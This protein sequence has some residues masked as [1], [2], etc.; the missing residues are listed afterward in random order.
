VSFV[1][2]R[3]CLLEALDRDGCPLRPQDIEL[4]EREICRAHQYMDQAQTLRT[5]SQRRGQ[6]LPDY[7]DGVTNRDRV[8]VIALPFDAH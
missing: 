1:D 2:N 7:D 4:L 5:A 6:G 3:R 8:S